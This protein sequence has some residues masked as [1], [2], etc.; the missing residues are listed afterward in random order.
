MFSV[1]GIGK[2]VGLLQVFMFISSVV[3]DFIHISYKIFK[4]V[5]VEARLSIMV[6]QS[7]VD[8][9]KCFGGI[10]CLSLKAQGDSGEEAVGLCK[11]VTRTVVG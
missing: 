4:A 1:V 10:D 7:V 8:G 3:E 9:C 5:I 11:Q 2:L 6:P